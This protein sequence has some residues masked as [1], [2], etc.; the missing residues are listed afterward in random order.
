LDDSVKNWWD[1][2]GGSEKSL[3]ATAGDQNDII[4]PL[5]MLVVEPSSGQ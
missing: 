2:R 5:H 1:I 4:L 3:F